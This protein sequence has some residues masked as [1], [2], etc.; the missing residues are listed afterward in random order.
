M[1]VVVRSVEVAPHREIHVVATGIE[2]TIIGS[3][4]ITPAIDD[5]QEV[6]RT[7]ITGIIDIH[8]ALARAWTPASQKAEYFIGTDRLITGEVRDATL[9]AH[10]CRA[11]G[12]QACKQGQFQYAPICH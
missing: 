2:R 7:D 12:Q 3:G 10:R 6:V 9:A 11:R 5:D 1:G 8:L 4:A